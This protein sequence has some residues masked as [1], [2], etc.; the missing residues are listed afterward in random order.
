MI[1][2]ELKFMHEN[3]CSSKNEGYKI[4]LAEM[5]R[6]LNLNDAEQTTVNP[7]NDHRTYHDRGATF[8]VFHSERS[9]VLGSIVACEPRPVML[10]NQSVV[11]TSKRGKV[12][13]SFENASIRLQKVLYICSLGYNLV[14][15]E[16]LADNGIHSLFF[17]KNIELQHKHSE[18]II[19]YAFRD[20][21][22]MLYSFPAPTV[23]SIINI[24]PPTYAGAML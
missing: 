18:L 9:F 14:S 15:V 13:C 10:A 12:I 22:T 21:D 24:V 8:H 11:T 17:S 5:L 16:R 6:C 7:P 23:S 1:A 19:D 2:N 3:R 20:E 4:E